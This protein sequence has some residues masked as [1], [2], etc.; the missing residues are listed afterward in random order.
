M[1]GIGSGINVRKWTNKPGLKIPAKDHTAF[2]AV[3]PPFIPSL[4][5]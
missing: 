5:K 3:Q 2:Q 4:Y 1:V